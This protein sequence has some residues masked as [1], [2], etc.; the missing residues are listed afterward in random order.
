MTAL[1]AGVVVASLAGSLHCLAMC[2]PL[3]GVHGARLALAHSL[4]RLATYVLLGALAGGLG[5]AL[6]LAGEL[7]AVQRIAILAAGATLVV[8]AGAQLAVAAGLVRTRTSGGVAFRAG[9]VAIRRRRPA[10]RAWLAGALV[11]LLP[12]GWLWAFVVAAA[13]TGS[14]LTGAAVMVAFWLGSLPAMIGA[15]TVLG[16]ALGWMR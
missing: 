8:W 14:P 2:G 6:D 12:C 10:A 13:G 4:G 5:H 7:A 11:G 9:L 16:P 3:A 1:F 15:L